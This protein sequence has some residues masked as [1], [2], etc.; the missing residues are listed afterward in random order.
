[1]PEIVDLRLEENLATTASL[2]GLRPLNS[3]IAD[4]RRRLRERMRVGLVGL[5]KVGKSVVANAFLGEEERAPTGPIEKSFNITWFRYDLHERIRIHYRD[6]RPPEEAELDRLPQLVARDLGEIAELLKIRYVEVFLDNPALKQFD[7]IDLPG[8]DSVYEDDS[9]RTREFL[10]LH[11]ADVTAASLEEAREADAYLYLFN[12]RGISETDQAIAQ[13]L[14][15]QLD[16]PLREGKSP[17]NSLGVLTHADQF[18]RAE[19][20]GGDGERRRSIERPLDA[21]R[22]I[23]GRL[24]GEP[25]IRGLFYD[26]RVVSGLLALG[27][28][29]LTPGRLQTLK[30]LAALPDEERSFLFESVQFLTGPEGTDAVPASDRKELVA[31][32]GFYGTWKAVELLRSG[33]D[34]PDDLRELLLAESGFPELVSLVQEHFGDRAYLIKLES[35]RARITRAWEESRRACDPNEREIGD[36]VMMRLGALWDSRHE[37]R[38]LDVLRD[39][40]NGRL[41]LEPELIEEALRVLGER[42]RETAVRL[43]ADPGTPISRLIERAIQR[44]TL[45]RELHQEP[46]LSGEDQRATDVILRSYERIVAALRRAERLEKEGTRLLAETRRIL[47]GGANAFDA[48]SWSESGLPE[49]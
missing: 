3:A 8:L 30:A 2:P 33:V 38:E 37:V 43:N 36:H 31:A 49:R 22:R 28:K 15:D 17:I 48:V 45:W 7:L 35:A 24:G 34:D 1:L 13:Q 26:L 4:S 29:T 20:L 27:A 41:T 46:V 6:D 23:A 10:K 12:R 19:D 21:A 18:W 5:I 40:Y 25:V 44:T 32:L 47:A 11:G 39:A 9:Q 14:A 42:G 16:G